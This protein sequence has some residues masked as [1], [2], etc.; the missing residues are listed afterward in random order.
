MTEIK[1]SKK[2]F[3][4]IAGAVLLILGIV[5]CLLISKLNK[6][7]FIPASVQWYIAIGIGIF[8]T[9]VSLIL[10][11]LKRNKNNTKPVGFG[12]WIF[13]LGLTCSYFTIAF[14]SLA[15]VLF[16]WFNSLF[17]TDIVKKVTLPIKATGSVTYRGNVEYYVFVDFE[18]KEEQVYLNTFNAST[19]ELTLQK[20]KFGYWVVKSSYVDI[21]H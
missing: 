1:N 13:L 4:V 11:F 12:W 8:G 14:G 19:I 3:K 6:E 17:A 5:W 9:V 2:S 21:L 18:G 20:G 7:T 16:L 15:V 10:L